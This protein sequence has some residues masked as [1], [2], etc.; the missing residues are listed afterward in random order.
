MNKTSEFISAEKQ[1]AIIKKLGGYE[2]AI[3]FLRGELVVVSKNSHNN[4]IN[5]V[6]NDTTNRQEAET[7]KAKPTEINC[8]VTSNGATGP[9]LIER[10]KKRQYYPQSII[11]DL[12]LSDNFTPTTGIT[13]EFVIP[14]DGY[15]KD[16]QVTLENV[17][18]ICLVRENCSDIKIRA[19]GLSWIFNLFTFDDQ[20][21]L[22]TK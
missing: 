2:G 6:I 19:I 21:W 11:R 18:A 22:Y 16:N 1:A 4:I 9:E 7:Q 15:V 17:E 3:K 20:M 13:K 12:L 10:L 14:K 5:L 8:L